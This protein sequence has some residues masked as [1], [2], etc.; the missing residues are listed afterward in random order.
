M[1]RILFLALFIILCVA[2]LY[3]TG[4][5]TYPL[6][7]YGHV[8][9]G[10]PPLETFFKECFFEKTCVPEVTK[11]NLGQMVWNIFVAIMFS[12]IGGIVV[13]FIVFGPPEKPS[14]SRNKINSND[15][16]RYTPVRKVLSLSHFERGKKNTSIFAIRFDCHDSSLNMNNIINKI[17][18]KTNSSYIGTREWTN[19]YTYDFKL[20]WPLKKDEEIQ[21]II[22]SL[23]NEYIG[24]VNGD[25]YYQS[26]S[27][28]T[29][30]TDNSIS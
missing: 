17:E 1:K 15:H 19:D 11:E 18:D 22:V 10:R 8:P 13:T 26:G 30:D 24:R 3:Y 2:G 20:D 27:N 16:V 25:R 5:V 23:N 6:F 29:D 12:I 7:N 21:Q 14:K 28:V 9:S 4:K